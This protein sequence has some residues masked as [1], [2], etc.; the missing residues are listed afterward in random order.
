MKVLVVGG[1]G[2]IGSHVVLLALEKGFKVTVFDNLSTSSKINV[3]KNTNFILGSINSSNDLK[4]LF[5]KEKYDVLIHLAASKAAGESMKNPLK[6]AKNNI[7]GGINL[8]SYSI[9]SG[10]K[11]FVFSSSAAVYGFPQYNPID[12]KHHLD[13]S[14][15]YGYTKLLIERN[16]TWFSK[17]KDIK[18]AS[19]RYFN[20]AGFDSLH[21]IEGLEDNPQNL[22]PIVMEVAARKQKKMKIYGNDYETEDGTGIRDYVHV[23]DLARA[24]IDSLEYLENKQK[25]LIVNLGVG[26]GYSVF[27]VI[28]KVEEVTK[29]KINYQIVQRRFGDT[30]EVIADS[31]LARKLIKWNPK[32]S[33]L[34]TIIRST[35]EIYKKLK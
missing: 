12:E 4:N 13:P 30:K 7:L 18:F 29:V 1:A 8:L 17:L 24:H 2:Y 23:S 10:I 25:N 11:R 22:I 5:T 3:N 6:Y 35:W 28:K 31:S 14:N 27:E 20:A 16:L 33:D 19:L 26:R 15:Y 34:D 9:E 21:R 32:S